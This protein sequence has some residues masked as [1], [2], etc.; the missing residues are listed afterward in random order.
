[1]MV[2][3]GNLRS[4]TEEVSLPRYVAESSILQSDV[5]EDVFVA[6]RLHLSRPFHLSQLIVRIF[7]I[8]YNCC[9]FLILFRHIQTGTAAAAAAL[10]TAG[11]FGVAPKSAEAASSKMWKPIKLPFEETLYDIDFDTYVLNDDE[12]CSLINS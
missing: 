10:A 8:T 6:R 2:T 9:L 12:S 1:M 3:V 5:D 11:S 4:R 7:L